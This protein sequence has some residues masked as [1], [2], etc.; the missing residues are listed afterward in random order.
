VKN[1]K[2]DPVFVESVQWL[3]FVGDVKQLLPRSLVEV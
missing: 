3:G 2:N 1:G